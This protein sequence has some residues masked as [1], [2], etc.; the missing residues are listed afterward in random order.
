MGNPASMQY[1]RTFM[2]FTLIG[3]LLLPG[4][5]SL[6]MPE[7]DWQHGAKRAVVEKMYSQTELRSDNVSPCLKN[8]PESERVLGQYAEVSH[9]EGRSRRWKSAKV[10][11]GLTVGAG[12]EVE[13]NPFTCGTDAVP[14]ITKVL[15]HPDSQ[16]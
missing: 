9:W 13:I 14:V 4:C 10:A 16:R 8:V 1:V 6:T 15:R 5:S 7:V 2:P 3:A 12:D 11:D